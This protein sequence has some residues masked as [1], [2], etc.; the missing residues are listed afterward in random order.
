[1][2]ERDTQRLIVEWMCLQHHA[3]ILNEI[4][5]S[6]PC[7]SSSTGRRSPANKSSSDICGTLKGGRAVWIEV[8]DPKYRPQITM[9]WKAL[10]VG[11]YSK[12]L[13][14]RCGNDRDT[15]RAKKQAEFLLW[16]RKTGALAFF[17]FD[18]DDVKREL[19]VAI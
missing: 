10:L 16:Q 15:E 12:Y 13:I 18:L 9:L 5:I 11:D 19:G 6:M 3:V 4:P 2:A 7:R 14:F 1:M 17:A 8:K